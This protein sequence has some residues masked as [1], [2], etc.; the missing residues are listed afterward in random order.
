[1]KLQSL[2]EMETT[3]DGDG[4][5]DLYSAMLSFA[6]KQIVPLTRALTKSGAQPN[7]REKPTSTLKKM[8]FTFMF[9]IIHVWL[10][11]I[12]WKIAIL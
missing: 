9:G 10:F 11:W 1:M 5:D 12:M 3:C 2:G 8:Y 6:G 7:T 4:L